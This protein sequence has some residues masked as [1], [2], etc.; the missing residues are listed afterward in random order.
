MHT[1]P[2]LA[3]SMLGF[4]SNSR[5]I[6]VSPSQVHVCLP[7]LPQEQCGFLKAGIQRDLFGPL[8]SGRISSWASVSVLAS[9]Y[10]ATIVVW[11]LSCWRCVP[12]TFWQLGHQKRLH[13]LWC[14][15][16]PLKKSKYLPHW[17]GDLNTL[18]CTYEHIRDSCQDFVSSI[19]G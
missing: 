18:T 7:L 8:A 5:Y 11:L 13:P 14:C 4:I 3:Y 9:Q 6:I 12:A 16:L 19:K 1:V 2:A 15:F 17:G 10:G